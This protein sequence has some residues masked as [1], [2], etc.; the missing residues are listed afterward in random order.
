MERLVQCFSIESEDHYGFLHER[1]FYKQYTKNNYVTFFSPEIY[2]VPKLDLHSLIQAL[3]ASP[4]MSFHPEIMSYYS[5][6][7]WE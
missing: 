5:D 7:L 3:L 2:I 4:S 1:N 6:K